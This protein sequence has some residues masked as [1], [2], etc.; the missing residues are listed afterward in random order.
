MPSLRDSQLAFAGS[1]FGELDGGISGQLV[2]NGLS[3][4]RRIQVYRNNML[5]SLTDTLGAV[6][7]VIRRL[8]G[9]AFFE[10]AAQDYIR[11]HPSRSGNLHD[12][13]AHFPEFLEAFPSA[14]E[15]DY[16]GDVARLEWAYHSAFHAADHPPLALDALV[17]VPPNEHGEIRFEL[18]PSARL[19]ASPLPVLRIWEV[20][21]DNHA[22][23]QAVSLDAGGV[24]L[25]VIRRGLEVELQPLGEAEHAFLQAIHD[26]VRFADAHERAASLDGHFDLGATLQQHVTSHTIVGFSVDPSQPKVD[27]EI[28]G[29]QE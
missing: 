13:G 29:A 3:P 27:T 28:T 7:P 1:V 22:D 15:L 18:H 17:T 19:L 5:A 23:D 16:L 10:Y 24:R 20:N 2:A 9:E 14:A 12:F 6:Y 25:L 26:G 8:V 21:Q 4:A 11:S